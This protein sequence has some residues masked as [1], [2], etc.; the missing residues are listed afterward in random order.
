MAK[1]RFTIAITDVAASKALP[2][3]IL[4]CAV[5]IAS[6]A[7]T[8]SPDPGAESIL[9]ATR[10]ELER[11]LSRREGW[12]AAADALDALGASSKFGFGVEALRATRIWDAMLALTAGGIDADPIPQPPEGLVGTTRVVQAKMMATSVATLVAGRETSHVRGTRSD[13]GGATVLTPIRDARDDEF[14]DGDGDG[15][16]AKIRVWFATNRSPKIS[17]DP[18]SGFTSIP[19]RTLHYG[20]CDVVI[21]K[22]EDATGGITRVVAGWFGLSSSHRTR[23][24]I[25]R[26]F[27]LPSER[28]FSR[29]LNDALARASSRTAL[30]SVHGFNT[31]FPDAVTSVAQLSVNLKH[32]GPTAVFS[33]PSHAKIFRY[34]DDERIVNLSRHQLAAFLTTI[35]QLGNLDNIDLVVHSLGSR[36]FLRTLVALSKSATSIHLPIRN[37]FL[38]APD[39]DRQ[40]FLSHARSFHRTSQMTTMYGS[41]SDTALLMSKIIHGQNRAGLMPPPT[42]LTGIDSIE[43]SAVDASR[44]RHGAVLN[45]AAVQSDMFIVQDSASVPDHRPNLRRVTTPSGPYWRF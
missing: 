29:E 43:T 18:Q 42:I 14:D 20:R 13:A 37:I 39:I 10:A 23:P 45:C 7:R 15:D 36:L 34:R 9:L 17:R 26:T 38:G 5:V 35:S 27:R 12:H 22:I 6:V 24:H 44:L 2:D 28:E 1:V 32:P 11:T 30:V 8:S 3:D 21:P 31:S 19:D 4:A 25:A 33:W 41:D 16:G 40:E